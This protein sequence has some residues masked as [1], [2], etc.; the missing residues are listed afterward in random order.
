MVRMI[1]VGPM[2]EDEIGIP[3]ADEPGDFPAVLQREHAIA[4]PLVLTEQ[5]L[6]ELL[7]LVEYLEKLLGFGFFTHC[8]PVSCEN[9]AQGAGFQVRQKNS[10]QFAVGRRQEKGYPTVADAGRLSGRLR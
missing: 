3:F 1:I 5:L 9:V 6:R 4:K 10:R 2:A 8:G 7:A